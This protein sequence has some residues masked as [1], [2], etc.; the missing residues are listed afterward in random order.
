VGRCRV[1]S[2]C[3]PEKRGVPAVSGPSERGEGARLRCWAAANWAGAGK[4]GSRGCEETGLGREGKYRVLPFFPYFFLKLSFEEN[5][6]AIKFKP[7]VNKT[8]FN[9]LQHECTTSC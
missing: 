3:Q 1:G 8:K 5:F 9:I 2:D 7:K 4:A 6:N